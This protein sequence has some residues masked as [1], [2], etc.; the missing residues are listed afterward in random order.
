MISDELTSG[1]SFGKASY[2]DMNTFQCNIQTVR[3]WVLQMSSDIQL[4]YETYNK[5]Y[6]SLTFELFDS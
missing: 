3:V 4:I 2:I 6:L 5:H 1:N